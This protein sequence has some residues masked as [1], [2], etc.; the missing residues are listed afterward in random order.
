[1]AD[2]TAAMVKELRERTGAAMMDCK[3]ALTKT[4]GDVEAAVEQ[5][6]KDGMAKADK[7]ASRVAADGT[8]AIAQ[9]DGAIAVV[10]VNC[11]TDFVAKGDD[12]Q[13]MAKRAASEALAQRP[14]SI[15]SL[16]ALGTPP[17]DEERRAMIAKIGENM[18][19]RRF[20]VVDKASGGFNYYLHGT[21]IGAVV[22]LEG[23]SNELA[24]DIAM[25]VS[26]MNPAYISVAHIPADKVAAEREI[27]LAQAAEKVKGKP[28]E[29]VEK[30]IGGVV[31]K[32]LNELTLVAQAFV[33]NPDQTIEQLLAQH[34]AKIVSF[35]RYEVGQGIEKE[36]VDFAAEV[37]A[38]AAAAG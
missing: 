10:E 3:K 15:E 35:V 2:I 17:L 7:K 27:A 24:R 29:I 30:I 5:M 8:I 16:T 25:Q 31:G 18:T 33:K 28:A 19:F 14:A 20:E 21:R 38:A 11:E 22:V 23:G 37:A 12:F 6:R 32:A 13:A 36:V 1:M 26:A 9:N 4:D 34:K